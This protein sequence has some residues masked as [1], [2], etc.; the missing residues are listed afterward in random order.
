MILMTAMLIFL[1]GSSIA[2]FLTL[3]AERMGAGRSIIRPASCCNHCGRPLSWHQKIPCFSYLFSRGACRFCRTQIPVRYF[4][5][6]LFGGFWAL[7]CFLHWEADLPAALLFFW[8]GIGALLLSLEDLKDCTVPAAF[9]AL[10]LFVTVVLS[11]GRFFILGPLLFLNL[12]FIFAVWQS[13]SLGEADFYLLL[14]WGAV[15]GAHELA[16]IL[17]IACLCG[18]VPALQQGKE[19]PLPFIPCLSAGLFYSLVFSSM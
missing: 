19:T 7:F 13:R 3:A 16:K 17:L 5:L 14:T 12:F 18:I 9:L 4:W 10:I 15:L 6:E 11:F 1:F 8:V 2:S